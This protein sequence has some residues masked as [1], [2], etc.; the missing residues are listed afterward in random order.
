M[1]TP[2]VVHCSGASAP[3]VRGRVTLYYVYKGFMLAEAIQT[4]QA[5]RNL[6]LKTGGVIRYATQ[7]G[8][9]Q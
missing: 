5:V 1:E 9:G 6:L 3:H 4:A 7:E 8:S 2:A